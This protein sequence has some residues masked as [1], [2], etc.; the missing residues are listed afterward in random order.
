MDLIRLGRAHRAIRIHLGR[1]QAD[2]AA[3]AGVSQQL[4]SDF[5][6]GRGG[7]MTLDGVDRLFRALGARAVVSVAWRGGDLDRLLDE[8][9]AAIEGFLSG[10]LRAD[11]WE[12]LT[13][14]TFSVYGERGSIDVLAWHAATRTLLVVE[15]KTEITSAEEMLRRHDVKV[16]LAPGICRERFGVA[17]AVV[18]R[19]LVLADTSRNRRHVTR[20]A[21][22]LDG[23][24]PTR[25]AALREWLTRPAGVLGGLLFAD[26]VGAGTNKGAV[27]PRR[28]RRARITAPVGV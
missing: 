26:T 17:P 8:G 2:V 25:G 3:G 5:E 19:L 20:L 9:H 14:V 1:R 10:R 7:S 4:V 15:V 21:S 18:A 13:E 6:R 23:V 27:R 16:R 11:G 28:V 24:Y 12:V 22:L